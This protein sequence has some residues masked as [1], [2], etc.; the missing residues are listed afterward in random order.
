M[1]FLVA[2]IAAALFAP[3]ASASRV[4][5]ISRVASDLAGKPV[6]V[7]CSQDNTVRGV[8]GAGSVD[9]IGGSTMYLA[10]IVCDALLLRVRNPDW[11]LGLV[12]IAHEAEHLK[13]VVDE[14]EAD[15]NALKVA[16]KVGIV[17]YRLTR[18]QLHKIMDR[19]WAQH[20]QQSAKYTRLC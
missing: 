2:V 5:D 13:G 16:A 10:R 19:A 12:T 17:Y 3:N 9:G 15:C 6:S 1:R 4:P 20:R 7:Q 18:K 8:A 14:S 11:A